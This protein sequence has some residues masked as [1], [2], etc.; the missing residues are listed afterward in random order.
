MTAAAIALSGCGSTT[1]T[2][3][4]PAPPPTSHTV[5]AP[6]VG[7]LELVSRLESAAHGASEPGVRLFRH[8]G[9]GGHW[10]LASAS[11]N[12]EVCFTVA[13]VG[14]TLET[15]CATRAQLTGRPPLV[16]SSAKPSASGHGWD[17]YVVYGLVPANVDKLA[18]NLS[19]CTLRAVDLSTR[20]LFWAFV[21]R[22]KLARNIL[23]VGYVAFTARRA[24]AGQLRPAGIPSGRCSAPPG[25]TR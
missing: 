10:I 21:P 4:A 22:A 15:S 25:A 5:S 17:G 19:D 20:P 23:P 12:G 14:T 18:V 24:I 3:P 16:Y 6:P 9:P 13:L 7:S 8:N 11:M 2:V 1:K